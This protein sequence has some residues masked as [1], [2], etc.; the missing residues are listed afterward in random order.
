[1]NIST[2][3]KKFF[4]KSRKSPAEVLELEKQRLGSLKKKKDLS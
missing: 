3:S 4:G 2:G 1:L